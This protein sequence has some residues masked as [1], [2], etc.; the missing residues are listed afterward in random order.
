MIPDIDVYAA[1]LIPIENDDDVYL[2]L[3]LIPEPEKDAD[4]CSTKETKKTIEEE[5]FENFEEGCVLTAALPD[6]EL[7]ITEM[8]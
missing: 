8:A 3:N 4:S 6:G 5:W 2:M 7:E 1:S